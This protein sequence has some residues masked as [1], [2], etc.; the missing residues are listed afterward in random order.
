MMDKVKIREYKPADKP[1]LIEILKLNTPKYFAESEADDLELYLENE[2][3]KYF[4][5]EIQGKIIGAG[6][7]NFNYYNKEGRISWDFIHPE[8][9]GKGI[10]QKLLNHRIELLKS[11]EN[12]QK[13]TV[14]TSQAAYKFY[15]KN[16]FQLQ[17]IIK[18]FWSEGFDLYRLKYE[19]EI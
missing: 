11:M 17:N 1:I 16:G 10:G 2:I 7:I 14:R 4:I 18:D 8:Y 9:Q 6:G 19:Y 13:I 3:E 5:I 12:I 15:E